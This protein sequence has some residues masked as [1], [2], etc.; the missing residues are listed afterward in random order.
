MSNDRPFCTSNLNCQPL[1]VQLH[2]AG[3]Q[4]HWIAAHLYRRHCDVVNQSLN[5]QCATC[6]AWLPQ[7]ITCPAKHAVRVCALQHCSQSTLTPL[8]GALAGIFFICPPQAQQ[9][10]LQRTCQMP[11]Q[12]LSRPKQCL[13]APPAET[14]LPHP[15]L[16][17]QTHQRRH[18]VLPVTAQKHC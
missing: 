13:R 7:R 5:L 2:V 1:P 16:P 8:A 18:S 9:Q 10:Q 11:S 15:V 12:R 6:Y 4:Q 14:V 17:M 3:S